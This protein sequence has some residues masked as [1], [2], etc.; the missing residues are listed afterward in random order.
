MGEKCRHI[1]RETRDV[2]Q[3]DRG[4]EKSCLFRRHAPII[5]AR[6]IFSSFHVTQGLHQFFSNF[7]FD[8]MAENC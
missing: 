4:K 5:K 3:R 8:K 7:F 6:S 2:F 1:V